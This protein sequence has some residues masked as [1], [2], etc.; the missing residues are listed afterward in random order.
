MFLS[1]AASSAALTELCTERPLATLASVG[2]SRLHSHVVAMSYDRTAKQREQ[3]RCFD[4]GGTRSGPRL[5]IA[6]RASPSK[7]EEQMCRFILVLLSLSLAS[8]PWRSGRSIARLTRPIMAAC[9]KA[10]TQLAY[11]Q[12]NSQT[13]HLHG[14]QLTPRSGVLRGTVT[15]LG[16]CLS[17]LWVLTKLQSGIQ[18]P[19][20]PQKKTMHTTTCEHRKSD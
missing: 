3:I 10:A 8:V 2:L 19:L 15:G 1:P 13:S 20:V 6:W 18:C 14:G 17:G 7:L 5:V 12:T 9:L 11:T 16:L 4:R